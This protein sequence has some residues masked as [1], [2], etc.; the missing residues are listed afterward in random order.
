[1]VTVVNAFSGDKKK[2]DPSFFGD[3]RGMDPIHCGDGWRWD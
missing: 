1:M 2:S 3:G